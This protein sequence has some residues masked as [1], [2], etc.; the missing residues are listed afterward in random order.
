ML[1]ME[2]GR[3]KGR[4]GER[5]GGRKG[6]RE[7]GREGGR[8]G[9][10]GGREGGRDGGREGGRAK[11]EERFKNTQFPVDG[12]LL[13]FHRAASREPPAPSI[14]SRL[15]RTRST[16]PDTRWRTPLAPD[17]HMVQPCGTFSPQ[18]RCVRWQKKPPRGTPPTPTFPPPPQRP[19][20]SATPPPQTPPTPS[21]PSSRPLLRGVGG[22]ADPLGVRASNLGHNVVYG[23][24]L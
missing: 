23:G 4:E 22:L 19:P 14:A 12:F 8:G 18:E 1:G 13:L 3:E 21:I 15:L 16:P 7:G 10:E 20:S 11:N 2:G 17:L 5:E 9:R 24:T 6:G